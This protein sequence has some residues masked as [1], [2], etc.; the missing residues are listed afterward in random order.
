MGPAA[1]SLS[2]ML[3]LQVPCHQPARGAFIGAVAD[4][5]QDL[6]LRLSACNVAPSCVCACSTLQTPIDPLLLC[7]WHHLFPVHPLLYLPNE[8]DSPPM[9][10]YYTVEMSY[11]S[12]PLH[13]TYHD[14]YGCV[15]LNIYYIKLS[16]SVVKFWLTCSS[17]QKTL[18]QKLWNNCSLTFEKCG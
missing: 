12:L 18:F 3:I 15:I 10:S 4:R 13:C 14:G 1:A 5:F 6:L 7:L 8:L 11:L 16:F 17:T 2:S 9:C